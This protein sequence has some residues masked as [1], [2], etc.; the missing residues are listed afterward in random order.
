MTQVVDILKPISA[1]NHQVVRVVDP[2]IGNKAVLSRYSLD[3]GLHGGPGR[4]ALGHEAGVVHDDALEA[5]ALNAHVVRQ[6]VELVQPALALGVAQ[7][8]LGAEHDQRLAEL[9][10]DL[11]ERREGQQGGA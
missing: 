7:Q 10:V 11:Y 3:P 2:C 8:V 9:T 6:V 5:H 4:A 1:P